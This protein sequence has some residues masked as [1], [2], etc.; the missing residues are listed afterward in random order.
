HPSKGLGSS[1]NRSSIRHLNSLSLYTTAISM[2]ASP[3]RPRI[4]VV[5]PVYEEATT[6]ARVLDELHGEF[7]KHIEPRFI[8]CEAG[9]RDGTREL[10]ETLRPR[11]PMTIYSPP[12]RR[13]YAMAIVEGLR[14]AETD[15]VLVLD[16][17]G[18]CDPRDL[19][20]LLA[21]RADADITVG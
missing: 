1:P 8:V 15:H 16:S 9:S 10:L 3:A 18:Q 12:E 5:L 17:D 21:R 7:S 2:P 14:A 19:Q 6:L 13:S 11:F 4:D 20:R